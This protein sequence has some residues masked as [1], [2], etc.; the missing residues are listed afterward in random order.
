MVADA[1]APVA[2]VK[3]V[4]VV[5]GALLIALAL[6]AHNP[7]ILSNYLLFGGAWRVAAWRF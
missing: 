1:V 6:V 7:I 5:M 2:S 3:T 4:L